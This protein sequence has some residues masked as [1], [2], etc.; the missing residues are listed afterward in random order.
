M[1]LGHEGEGN[2]VPILHSDTAWRKRESALTD[3]DSVVSLSPDGSDSRESSDSKGETHFE[4]GTTE[5]GGRD[6]KKWMCE[7][8]RIND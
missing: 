1:V 7:N 5:K 6:S 4:W 2:G 8:L 3:S